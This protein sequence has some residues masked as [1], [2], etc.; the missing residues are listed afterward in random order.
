MSQ[1]DGEHAEV[2][3]RWLIL[4]SRSTLGYGAINC[5]LM[6]MFTVHFISYEAHIPTFFYPCV[7]TNG[8]YLGYR[9]HYVGIPFA[10]AVRVIIASG[11]GSL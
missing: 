2:K 1:L 11:R 9:L 5:Y 4:F 3:T 10:E 7:L 6:Q 8:L